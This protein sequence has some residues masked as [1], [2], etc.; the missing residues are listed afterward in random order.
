M[1]LAGLTGGIGS[2]KSTVAARFRALGSRVIDADEV[3]REVV[4]PGEP[5]LDELVEHFGPAILTP[6]GGLDRSRLAG[7]VFRDEESR[8]V[9]ERITHPRIE[10]RIARRVLEPPVAGEDRGPTVVDHPLLIE[11][12][13]VGRFDAVV[14]VVTDED[15]RIRRLVEGRQIR[16][17]DA[18]A[19][20]RAQ[21]GDEARIAAA[22][23]VIENNGTLEELHT[24]VDEVHADLVRRASQRV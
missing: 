23:H 9:L 7:I 14:V 22:T 20:I 8:R 13:Q 19:R 3:A 16:V 6:H 4:A 11:T 12:G 24:R 15:V 10:E 5:A 17:D 2:G 18:H 1:Y 21:A